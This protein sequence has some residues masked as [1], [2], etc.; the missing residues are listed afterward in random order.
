MKYGIVI[1]RKTNEPMNEGYSLAEVVELADL[2]KD[3]EM[4]IYDATGDLAIGL[5]L[6]LDMANRIK[7]LEAKLGS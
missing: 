4:C 2:C 7:E 5:K 1:S 3:G 6:L